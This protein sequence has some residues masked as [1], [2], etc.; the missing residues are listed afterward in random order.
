VSPL[1]KEVS[2]TDY[3]VFHKK[4]TNEELAKLSNED[5][6]MYV[7]LCDWSTMQEL[8]G[9]DAVINRI[10]SFTSGQKAWLSRSHSDLKPVL[11]SEVIRPTVSAPKIICYDTEEKNSL[12]DR[13]VK[14]FEEYVSTDSNLLVLESS[15]KLLIKALH[16]A[17][18]WRGLG[19]V[20]IPNNSE[21]LSFTDAEKEHVVHYPETNLSALLSGDN[22]YHGVWADYCG[23]YD[24]WSTDIKKA[25]AN[26]CF[27]TR[28]VLIATFSSRGGVNPDNMEQP[29]ESHT[30][31]INAICQIEYWAEH[32][33]YKARLLPITGPYKGSGRMKNM[34]NLA[35]EITNL[36]EAA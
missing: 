34:Y 22:V 29:H 9:N 5:L 13:I 26:N 28:S 12:R 32:Y 21:T 17:P 7:R 15:A 33:G 20:Y 4:L 1:K 31:W 6:Y 23:C 19:R 25:F 36:K 30:Y 3:N 24:V 2:S 10:R 18:Y 14:L 35:F 27:A 8:C 11:K 16:A